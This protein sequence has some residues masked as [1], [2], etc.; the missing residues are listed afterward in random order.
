LISQIQ[1]RDVAP[2][3]TVSDQEVTDMMNMLK[4]HPDMLSPAPVAASPNAQYHLI[5][6]VV[7][8][9]QDADALLIKLRKD[10]NTEGVVDADPNATGNDL[11]W[12]RLSE[13]P[14]IFVA[15]TQA[16]SV[17]QFSSPIRAPNGYHILNLLAVNGANPAPSENPYSLQSLKTISQSNINIMLIKK[18]AL[19]SDQQMQAHLNVLR[20]QIVESGDFAQVAE[21]N[22]QDPTTASKGGQLGWTNPGVLPP[23]VD[24]AMASL[25]IGEVS[26]P[27]ETPNGYYII[28]VT[29]KRQIDN[30]KD[31][32]KDRARQLVYQRKYATTLQNWLVAVRSQAYVKIYDAS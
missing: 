16:L 32:L 21:M 1:Q 29:A 2:M 6:I 18:S 25:K 28:Q 13:M 30:S 10:S 20:N 19:F 27:I 24:A 4:T 12:R 15:P 14:G 26:Q 23:Q 9:Q 22:S 5:D 11:G 31:A 3:V 7:P 17:G 8:T